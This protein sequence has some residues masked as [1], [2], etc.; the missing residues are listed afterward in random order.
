MFYIEK[1]NKKDILYL[2]EIQ[3][4]FLNDTKCFVTDPLFV[5]SCV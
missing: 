5:L 3:Q 4:F 1:N 2:C